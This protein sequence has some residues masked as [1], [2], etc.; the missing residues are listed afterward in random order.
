MAENKY[1]ITGGLDQAT[2]VY[3]DPH[4]DKT[5]EL[6]AFDKKHWSQNIR[7]GNELQS[8]AQ[9]EMFMPGDES[10]ARDYMVQGINAPLEEYYNSGNWAAADYAVN[11]ALKF[12]TSDPKLMQFKRN[13]NEY[14]EYEALKNSTHGQTM[15]IIHFGD[16][17]EEFETVTY[18]QEGNEQLNV[19]QNKSELRLD[20][21]TRKLQL[22]GQ[23]AEAGE[24]PYFDEEG[25]DIDGDGIIDMLAYG[26]VG[27][28][29]SQS[30]INQVIDATFGE[31]IDTA[32]GIQEF[33]ELTQLKINPNTDE[34]YTDEEAKE[35]IVNDMR[36]LAANQRKGG[37]KTAN[38]VDLYEGGSRAHIQNLQGRP[39]DVLTTMIGG[40]GT[41]GLTDKLYGTLFNEHSFD[42]NQGGYNV[43]VDGE[44]LMMNFARDYNLFKHVKDLPKGVS[45]DLF[46][47]GGD[48]TEI[49]D[50]LVTWYQTSSKTSGQQQLHGDLTQ[51]LFGDILREYEDGAQESLF[52]GKG[53]GDEYS[54]PSDWKY[55]DGDG[56]DVPM[57]EYYKSIVKDVLMK[58]ANLDADNMGMLFNPQMKQNLSFKKTSD[59]TEVISEPDGIYLVVKGE[60]I[61]SANQIGL[62]AE[63]IGLDAPGG[64]DIWFSDLDIDEA[65]GPDGN[66]LVR[67]VELKDGEEG[68]AISGYQKILVSD[69][70]ANEFNLHKYSKETVAD[71]D[72]HFNTQRMNLL[73]Q[74]AVV[75][76]FNDDV[77]N[78]R[79]VY[80]SPTADK[81]IIMDLRGASAGLKQHIKDIQ[82]VAQQSYNA[83][84]F[85]TQ[86]VTGAPGVSIGGTNFYDFNTF[87]LAVNNEVA[88]IV[89]DGGGQ[90]EI[91][92]KLSELKR[93]MTTSSGFKWRK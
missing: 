63:A 20:G 66:Y 70:V 26:Q 17:P 64:F 1:N 92:N 75:Q 55:T 81:P 12:S 88:Q 68:Y 13:A 89:A 10:V 69:A 31:Y 21:S 93:D 29:V 6:Y 40:D 44:P 87:I 38:Y 14:K 11:N 80:K 33:E 65:K 50:D 39:D 47:G 41:F 30:K 60:Y 90:E 61:G 45:D 62:N 16:N 82:N 54:Y 5:L 46:I 49:L 43:G 71:N 53:M 76:N 9:Q 28:G 42:D 3:A 25:I 57:S 27:G 85:V 18:D 34:L 51:Q 58:N 83:G 2:P 24:S 77:S 78:N 74:K 67:E 19:F 79:V 86:A 7:M 52:T 15:G 37:S 4:L 23:I 72:R 48:K 35:K 73:Q 56:D 91:S 32:E 8:I 59:R 22:I 84:T 36:G